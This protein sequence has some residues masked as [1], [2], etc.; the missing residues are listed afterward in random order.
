M[1][2]FAYLTAAAVNGGDMA[3]EIKARDPEMC[4]PV[5][6]FLEIEPGYEP[7]AIKAQAVIARSNLYRKMQE[8]KS[9][10]N[11]LRETG[12]EI[13]R[14]KNLQMMEDF[15]KEKGIYEK[16]AK[17]TWGYVLSYEG[18]LCLV[19][20]HEVSAGR[21][22][23]GEE[24]LHSGEYAYLISVDS[25][26]D[27]KSEEYLSGRYALPGQI[28]ENLKIKKRDSAG[29]VT[30]LE[31]GRYFL[32]GEAFSQGVGLPSSDFSIQKLEEGYY[33]V[34][35]GRGHGLGFSQYGGN[36]MAK[37][38]KNWKEILT[39]YFPKMEIQKLG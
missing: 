37:E 22:R 6:L 4:I 1:V 38:G 26:A 12:K 15:M 3:L 8:G 39:A 9:L 36:A 10:G 31:A 33:F 24:A 29:Y 14:K 32:E 28:P 13:K 2:L 20:Y 23:S 27:K 17:E 16:A 5:L 18:S 21:T 19:P 34:C 7:E 30:E 25:Q 35:R 11:I